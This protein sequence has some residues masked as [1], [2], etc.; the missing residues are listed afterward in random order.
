MKALESVL[1]ITYVP[2]QVPFRSVSFL[3]TILTILITDTDTCNG[4]DIGI[5]IDI[6]IGVGVSA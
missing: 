3:L 6:D 5:D 2:C 4:D 1:H